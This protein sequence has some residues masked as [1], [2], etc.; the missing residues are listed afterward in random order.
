MIG[1]NIRTK[2]N[3][4]PS[5]L[6]TIKDRVHNGRV[7]TWRPMRKILKK[8]MSF[9]LLRHCQKLF[10]HQIIMTDNLYVSEFKNNRNQ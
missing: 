1:L 3:T 5:F 7:H 2:N 9:L 10:E 8:T 6:V 4:K